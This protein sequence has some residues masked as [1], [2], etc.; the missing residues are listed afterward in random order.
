MSTEFVATED[1]T[2]VLRR[3]HAPLSFMLASR[4]SR[5]KPL[6]Y[7]DGK[8]NRAL[9]YAR[10]QRSPFEDEQDG[11]AI[12]EPIIFEDGFLFVPKTNPVLQ[13]FMSIHPGHGSIFV[14][15]NPEKDAMDEV[16]K[17]NAEVEALV[18][19]REL[20][21]DMLETVAR[22]MLGAKVDKMTSAELKRDVL[23]YAKK[24][25]I[26]FLEM[27]ADPM[28]K[29]QS[30]VAKFFDEGLLRTRNNARDIYFNLPGNKSKM[31]TVPYGENPTFIVTSYLQSDEGI[32]TYKL[33]ER[34]LPG[35]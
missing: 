21:I 5:R 8:T 18:K 22:V 11:N 3:N 10:N 6:L 7:F 9:R 19:A 14:E 16:E 32:E 20:D 25:P 24:N 29:L 27:L 28:L 17:L 33:L 4:N 34:N 13:H 30:T 23:V 31:L 15:L 1:K 35:E 2:Y 26:G 12:L